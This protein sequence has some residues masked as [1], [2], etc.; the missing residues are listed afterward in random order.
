MCLFAEETPPYISDRFI[1][2]ISEDKSTHVINF[3]RTASWFMPRDQ[4]AYPNA[5]KAAFKYVPGLLKAYRFALAAASDGR[6]IVWPLRMSPIRHYIEE[7][8][9]A[10]IRS[11]APA[12]YHN[13]LVPKYPFGC[14]R[15][16]MDPG[17]LKSLNRS[18]VELVTDG[19]DTITENGIRG[20]SGKEYEFDVLILGTGFDVVRFESSL[21]LCLCY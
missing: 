18:N 4:Y 5:V 19:I 15:I 11:Q 13:F 8:S 10:Y 3:S 20:K 7:V 1:P 6:Y 14:K 12:K 16:I 21:S 17:Y 9:A 2:I